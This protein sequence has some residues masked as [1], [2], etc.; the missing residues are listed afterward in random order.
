MFLEVNTYMHCLV[1]SPI[2]NNS[3]ILFA[4]STSYHHAMIK[5]RCFLPM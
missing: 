5:P 1:Q 4:K 2:E 3:D